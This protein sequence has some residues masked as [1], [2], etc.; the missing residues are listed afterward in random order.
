MK[1]F[2]FN[3]IVN[4]ATKC[5]ICGKE[6]KL[7]LS[8]YYGYNII[9]NNKEGFLV[10]KMRPG[11]PLKD[12]DVILN[13]NNGIIIKGHDKI[14][15]VIGRS[16][17][18]EIYKRCKTCDFSIQFTLSKTKKETKIYYRVIPDYYLS[19]ESIVFFQKNARRVSV[20]KSYQTNDAWSHSDRILIY[21]GNKP[22]K[23]V[24]FDTIDLNSIKNLKH[25]N[26]VL[27]LIKTF[28]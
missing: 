8:S 24:P 15:R 13:P 27:N 2:S 14:D 19:S 23:D 25:M 4:Y 28:Q 5:I 20:Y 17:T 12:H 3:E 11:T 9:L 1:K 22:I 7:R 18:S 16:M 26:R 21:I 10:S 6:T